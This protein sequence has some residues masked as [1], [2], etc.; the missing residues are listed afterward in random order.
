MNNTVLRQPPLSRIA[1]K[2]RSIALATLLGFGAAFAA[3]SAAQALEEVNIRDGYAVHGYDVVAYFTVGQPT[4]GVDRF[5][6]EYQGAT[7]RFANAAHRDTF[8]ADPAK[9]APQYGGY[10]AFGTAVGRKFDGDPNAWRIVEGKLYLNV[11][12]QVQARWLKD[13]AG[14]IRSADRNWSI[15]A[16]LPDSQLAS[17]PPE[18]LTLGAS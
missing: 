12:K 15:I 6:A 16:N 9:Y 3:G 5:T 11:N 7:Y 14:F 2:I 1:G 13:T 18:G 17:N 8:T 10:C 4:K